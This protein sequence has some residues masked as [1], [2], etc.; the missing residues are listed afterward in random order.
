MDLKELTTLASLEQYEKQAKDLLEACEAGDARWIEHVKRH[1]PRSGKLPESGNPD[2]A[3][4][5]ADAQFALARWYY[6]ESWPNVV[7]HVEA[8]ADKDSRVLQF[9]LAVDAVVTGDVATLKRLLREN[10][11]LIRARSTRTHR[12][13][14][15]L[16]VGANGTDRQ[17]TP[18][19]AV[20]VA[21]VLIQAGA[22][23]DAVGKMYGG[24]TTLGLVATS[25]HPVR[26][27]VQQ[28]LID[29][30]LDRGAAFEGAV[31]QDYTRGS[32]VNACL[33]NGRGDAAEYLATRG[34]PLDVEGAAGV[35]RLDV[36]KSFV[37]EDGSLKAN[38]TQDQVED[39]FMWA[40]AYGRTSVVE[41]LLRSGVDVD[42]QPHGETGLHQAA[43]G[44]HLD[45]V[46]LLL[47]RKTPVDIKDR[48]YEGTPLGWALY[49]WSNA[50]PEAKGARYYEVVSLLVAAR[51]T[52][53]PEWL[54]DEKVRADSRMLAALTKSV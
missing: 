16:Y 30:L 50:P 22:E 36:V 32:I 40:C 7:E 24:T 31:A 10:P 33:H 52:V 48:S 49:G 3:I 20:Q 34:A 54:A 47:E 45:I 37:N 53:Q 39:G 42:V 1:L 35:G 25:V 8:L 23:V 5:L 13:T 2:E 18:K 15:L 17:M 9:E 14:L 12:A 21:K 43:Y 4:T 29:I 41:F 19:N 46:Q 11:E 26:T 6:F 38:A 27:R 44:G 28:A 51:S